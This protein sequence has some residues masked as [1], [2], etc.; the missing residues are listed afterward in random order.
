MIHICRSG[1]LKQAAKGIFLS[2]TILHCGLLLF[3]V[4]PLGLSIRI[5]CWNQMRKSCSAQWGFGGFFS[6]FLIYEK[7]TFISCTFL[8]LS[9]FAVVCF[10]FLLNWLLWVNQSLWLWNKE[11]RY[12]VDLGTKKL[13]S[14]ILLIIFYVFILSWM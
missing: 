9:C 1:C 8:L 2:L 7:L 5:C 11:V 12:V 3:W 10:D 6:R 14:H 13:V 4:I